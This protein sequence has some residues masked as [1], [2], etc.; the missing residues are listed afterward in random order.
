MSTRVPFCIAGEGGYGPEQRLAEGRQQRL[1][2]VDVQAARRHVR[3]R[4]L[5]GQH[6][7][8]EQE[9]EEHGDQRRRDVEQD[10]CGERGYKGLHAFPS[11][12]TR[13]YTPFL[14]I[15][16]GMT[17]QLQGIALPPF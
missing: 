13:D 11:N 3:R 12:S 14:L 2:G 8:G 15:L 4:G 1:C 7:Q 10:V 9:E 16:Q 5:H 6:G 17:L